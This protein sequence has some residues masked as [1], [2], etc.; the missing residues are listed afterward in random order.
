LFDGDNDGRMSL[1]VMTLEARV[2]LQLSR[3][4]PTRS[5]PA[6]WGK[7]ALLLPIRLQLLFLR[8][9]ASRKKKRVVLASKHKQ[10]ASSDQV[11][12]ELPPLDV[13][14]VEFVFGAYLKL[15]DTPLRLLGPE[16]HM[17]LTPSQPKN[18][19]HH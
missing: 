4:L 5:D 13:V 7:S 15:F 19:R 14:A 3:L 1:L 18:L 8:A 10:A 9:A 17:G 12:T 11:T 16:H 6:L 2:H